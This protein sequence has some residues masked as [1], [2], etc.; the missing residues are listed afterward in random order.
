MQT[1]CLRLANFS[2]T[3]WLQPQFWQPVLRNLVD[4]LDTVVVSIYR[5]ARSQ[6]GKYLDCAH[7]V[8]LLFFSVNRAA[9]SHRSPAASSIARAPLT[10]LT[11]NC[12]LDPRW[13]AVAASEVE[14][15]VRSL[16]AFLLYR[17]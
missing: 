6:S 11:Q 15:G 13:L 2:G 17:P 14:T 9:H 7:E 4:L 3:L 8:D 5:P 12:G 16:Q 10:R 1:T